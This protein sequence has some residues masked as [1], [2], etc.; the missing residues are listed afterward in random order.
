VHQFGASLVAAAPAGTCSCNFFPRNY[1]RPAQAEEISFF[2]CWVAGGG[3]KFGPRPEPNWV[4]LRNETQAC[5]L[6]DK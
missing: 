5:E 1:T 4:Y 6:G 3:M 2:S